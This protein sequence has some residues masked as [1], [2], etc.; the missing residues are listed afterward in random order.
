[1]LT[2]EEHLSQFSRLLL[3]SITFFVQ[4][5]P[6]EMVPRVDKSMAMKMVSAVI[7][8]KRV[9]ANEWELG[10][11]WTGE[12]VEIGKD[13]TDLLQKL[14]VKGIEDLPPSQLALLCNSD[15]MTQVPYNNHN[16]KEAL[17]EWQAL[18][19]NSKKNVPICVIVD[20]NKDDEAIL[21]GRAIISARQGKISRDFYY[22]SLTSF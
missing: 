9:T 16:L 17:E 19:S 12:D 20:Q 5:L 10:P 1:M 13:Y 8:N 2:P 22:N 15:A 21:G 3:Q 4:Q 7:D 11:G 18:I 6:P 14:N